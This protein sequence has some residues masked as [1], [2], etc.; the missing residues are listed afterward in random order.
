MPFRLSA[1]VELAV[2][3][4]LREEF[5]VIAPLDDTAVFHNQ[6]QVA[7]ADRGETVR[8]HKCGSALHQLVHA[9]LYDLFGTGID[10][11]GRL[12]ENQHRRVGD[13]R[14]GD[15]KELA[16]ALGEVCAV[17]M[18]HGLVAV[19]ETA[20]EA[21]GVGQFCRRL[22]LFIGGIQFAE[23]DVIGDGAGEQ[24]GLLQ[25][26]AEGPAQ[27]RLFDLV[28]VDIVIA[29]FTALDIVETIDQVGDRRLAGAGRT[30][31]G[32]FLARQGMQVDVMQ[33][34]FVIG[35][36]EIDV[37]ER[38]IAFQRHIG[39]RAV[40]L[41]VMFPCPV[42]GMF[43]GLLETADD[44]APEIFIQFGTVFRR[45]IGPDTGTATD[46]D[47][48]DIAV[49]LLRLGIEEI[50]DSLRTGQ[51][52][53]NG[54]DLHRNLVDRHAEVLVEGQERGQCTYGKAGV[55]IQRN[56]AAHDCAQ[57]IADIAELCVDRAEN[58]GKGVGLVGCLVELLVELIKF[59]FGFIF[60]IEDLDYL[61]TGHR[62]FDKTV[63]LSELFL[64]QHEVFAGH[65]CGLSRAEEHQRYHAER[66]KGQRHAEHEHRDQDRDNRDRAVEHHRQRLADHLPQRIDIVCVD[67]HDVAVRVG[68]K[69]PDRQRFHV[70][71]YLYTKLFHRSLCDIG[72]QYG[73]QKR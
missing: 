6:D 33:H 15:G 46:V 47:E 17:S 42:S 22:H 30:D 24:I 35:V 56:D 28:D 7:V 11:G 69:I 31:E 64:L 57:N 29:D 50:E 68:I 10:G 60:M 26:N 32:D 34:D 48:R 4:F 67:R 70:F 1:G 51:C 5:F 21:V 58:V 62:L 55:L 52:R 72:H 13:R 66:Q 3:A 2:A 73:L 25:D 43:F 41:V 19:R 36:A 23:A 38:D 61:F 63:E 40:C 20:D 12:I 49:I 27:V 8:D 9:A 37:L 65:L 44:S 71:E 18:Q 16:L 59:F 14:T 45:V 53:D 54:I 39:R